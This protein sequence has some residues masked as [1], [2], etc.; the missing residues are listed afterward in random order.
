MGPRRPQIACP[1][2]R[3]LGKCDKN[4]DDKNITVSRRFSH[5][6]TAA[7]FAPRA[8]V[9]L[10]V[11]MGSRISPFRILP[12]TEEVRIPAFTVDIVEWRCDPFVP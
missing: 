10:R 8:K 7:V 6:V 12:A 5:Q 3:V 4:Y 9:C 2:R 11:V 1:D